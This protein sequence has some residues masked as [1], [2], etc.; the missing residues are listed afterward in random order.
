MK[1]VMVCVTT[2]KTCERLIKNGHDFLGQDEGELFIIHV[3]HYQYKF[4]GHDEDGEALE[5]LYEKALEFGANLTV[6]RSNNVLDTLVE[7]VEKNQ[8]SHVILGQSGEVQT[9]NNIIDINITIN[10]KFG[11]SSLILSR[12]SNLIFISQIPLGNISPLI[13]LIRVPSKSENIISYFFIINTYLIQL[14]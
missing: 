11:L 6:V 2:Q 5:Y 10:K 8:I 1:N 9:E 7:L 12:T 13:V 3:A 4:L 14:H